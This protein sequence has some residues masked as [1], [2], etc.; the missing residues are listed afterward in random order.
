MSLPSV[1]AE[2]LALPTASFVEDAVCAYVR[3]I[4]AKLSGVT[5]TVDRWGNLLVRYSRQ[6]Q[7]KR[8]PVFT[9][10]MDHP[11]F[12]ALEMWKSSQLRAAFRGWVEPEYFPGT[13]VRFWDGAKWVKGRVHKISKQTRLRGVVGRSA[14]PEEVL[15]DMSAPVPANS[16][17]MW[18][19]PEARLRGG[20]VHARGCDDIAGCAAMVALLQRLS[21]QRVRGAAYCLFTRAEEVGFIGAIGAA[22]SG[23]IPRGLPIVA[24]ETSRALT[25]EMIGAGPVLRVGDKASVFTPEVTAFCGRMAQLHA[26]KHKGFR[27]QRKLMDGGT[28]ESTAY[29]AYGYPTTGVCLALGNYHNMNVQTKRIEP[30]YVSLSDWEMMVDWFETIVR[31][32]H[33]YPGEL[34]S[35]KAGLEKRFA[36]HRQLL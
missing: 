14:R 1:L 3:R 32:A 28:C 24:I 10:H 6:P 9:A 31:E 8:P 16:P 20:N 7:A 27:F 2:M 15:I 11:G 22:K 4:C 13:P 23:T 21:R 34:T 18:D 12:I 30:E 33:R 19:L 29:Y 36:A 26:A 35:I 25:P 5:L 17:G